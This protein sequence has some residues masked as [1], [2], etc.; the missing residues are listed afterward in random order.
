M[1]KLKRILLLGAAALIAVSLTG[2]G[3]PELYERILIHGI[4]VDWT[5]DG[6]KVTV[7]SSVSPEAEGEELYTSDGESVL[8]A[9]SRLSLST[10]REPFYAHNYL[11]VF[12]M[13]AARRGLEDCLDFFV[14]YYNTRPAVEL[15]VSEGTA[16][17]VLSTEQEGKL[18]KMSQL[19][20]LATAGDYNGMAAQVD[21]LDFVN[22]V[23]RGGAL[24][25]VLRAGEDGVEVA[26]SAYFSGSN[27]VGTL[28]L[29]ETRGWMAAT[30]CLKRGEIIV[31][32][33]GLG[34]VTLSIRG[35]KTKVKTDMSDGLA[36]NISAE[37]DVDV[38]S[39]DG[40]EGEAPQDFYSRLEHAAQELIRA[41]MDAAIRKAA[42]DGCDIFGLG[43][44]LYR[45]HTAVWR[46]YADNWQ[47]RL[48]ECPIRAEAKVKVRRLEQEDLTGSYRSK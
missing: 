40:A 37:L 42:G 31:S 1:V 35:A 27:Y 23:Q 45:K 38:S 20:S 41:E 14:R 48:P 9:L 8:D 44:L 28:S 18:L 12:G 21:I 39:I 13:D 26:A 25:P 30:G 43:S 15:F 22:G 3:Y 10:G 36:F 47:E 2:C 5:G 34:T 33:A 16:E 46:Q 7:R 4:G 32:E 19:Q 17:E 29:D 24:L 11:V 6:Y